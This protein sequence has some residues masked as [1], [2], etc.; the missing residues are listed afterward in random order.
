MEIR[1]RDAIAGSESEPAVAGRSK[2]LGR[3]HRLWTAVARLP[4]GLEDRKS[5]G[6]GSGYM[7]LLR[8]WWLGSY[9][10]PSRQS[11]KRMPASLRATAT[12]AMNFPRRCSICAA[13]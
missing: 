12:V 2:R 5:F 7:A 9:V 8:A 3:I 6:V 1:R 13:H 10:E 4:A 11:A